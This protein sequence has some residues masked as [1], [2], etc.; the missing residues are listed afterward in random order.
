MYDIRYP[1]I[2]DNSNVIYHILQSW[3]GDFDDGSNVEVDSVDDDAEDA[4]AG[5]GGPQP[6]KNVKTCPHYRQ[7]TASHTVEKAHAAFIP[8]KDQ[9][10]CCSLG[11]EKTK[12]GTHDIEDLVA[13]GKQPE[14]MRGVALYRNPTAG[15]NSF[16][17][18]LGQGKFSGSSSQ[19][20][21]GTLI[22]DIAID[23][24]AAVEKSL[25]KGDMLLSCNGKNVHRKILSEITSEIR[26]TKDPL[27]LNVHRGEDSTSFDEDKYSSHAACP[28][29]LS[30]ALST[31]ADLVFAPYN[32]VLD[33][34]IRSA[35][36]INLQDSI[37]VLDEAH[38]VED[39]LRQLGS[40]TF[41][42]FDLCNV[43]AMLSNYASMVKCSENAI[44]Q[45][46]KWSN[47]NTADDKEKAYIPDVAHALLLFMDK[48][49]EFLKESRESF[50]TKPGM[51]CIWWP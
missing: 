33:P 46:M 18:S 19:R 43:V 26:K 4:T 37:V 10:S 13:F 35:M 41:G 29:Y 1:I 48:I 44:D 7:L 15:T 32:Y 21:N 9:V 49:V 17:L 51:Y 25:A 5:A 20:R 28:Y 36:D 8:K 31:K 30:R 40:G 34:A 24:A 47:G 12:L 14:V 45:N 42:E 38:N 22:R 11:G 23:G 3:P 16:G 39:T 50:E 6:R 27:L 2:T